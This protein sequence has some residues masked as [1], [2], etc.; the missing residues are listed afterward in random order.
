MN[1]K[2]RRIRLNEFY[3]HNK[4]VMR[5]DDVNFM[6]KSVWEGEYCNSIPRPLS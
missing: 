3:L 4:L 6:I 5:I 1:F 2:S